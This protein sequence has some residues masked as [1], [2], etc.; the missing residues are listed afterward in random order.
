MSSA[1]KIEELCSTLRFVL[2]ALPVLAGMLDRAGMTRGANKAREMET[3]V[4]GALRGVHQPATTVGTLL[5]WVAFE[6][7]VPASD[8]RRACSIAPVCRARYAVMWGARS[9]LSLSYPRIG[10]LLDR[11]HTTICHGVRRAERLRASDPAFRRLTE[12][13][14]AEFGEVA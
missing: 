8:I 10:Q 1:A 4:A 11:D 2:P 7:G 3:A 14:R 9:I 12:R 6:M 5:A 13:M